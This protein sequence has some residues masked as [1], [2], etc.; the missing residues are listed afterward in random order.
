MT[1]ILLLAA[2]SAVCAIVRAA[3]DDDVVQ[4]QQPENPE[5]QMWIQEWNIEQFVFPGFENVA[6]AQRQ[7][8]TRAKLYLDDID[9]TCHLNE[10]QRE[11]LELAV[12]GDVK[13]L[14]REVDDLCARFNKVKN[15]NNAIN[16]FWP[17]IQTLQTKV[18]QG[19]G[20]TGSILAKTL[21]PTLTPEQW[22]ECEAAQ[23]ARALWSYEA[24]I[25]A[26]LAE[27][28][29]TIA[30]SDEQHVGIA[31]LL[32]AETPPPITS[33]QYDSIYVQYRLANLP[34]VKLKPLFN[35]EQYTLLE[36]H[37]MGARG[38]KK[39]L[40]QQGAISLL[41]GENE[42]KK[43]SRKQVESAAAVPAIVAPAIAVPAAPAEPAAP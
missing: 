33:G 31:Q 39:F 1:A 7:S 19:A 16:Q 32:L 17:E 23:K 21:R 3:P 22:T 14:F 10:E 43:K 35:G 24:T 28:E 15:E 27:L 26:A 36:R 13:R 25:E 34:A 9:R 5:Q 42:R 11:K 8:A 18:G 12:A 29:N 6:A 2:C 20:G 41:E 37:L 4:E 40:I 38:M 30:L